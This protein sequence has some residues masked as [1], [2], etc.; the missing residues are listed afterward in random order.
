MEPRV[1]EDKTTPE[2]KK[3]SWKKKFDRAVSDVRRKRLTPRKDGYSPLPASGGKGKGRAGAEGERVFT[4]GG[5]DDESPKD[6]GPPS[7]AK[8]KSSKLGASGKGRGRRLEDEELLRSLAL[9][10]SAPQ[11]RNW[12]KRWLKKVSGIKGGVINPES[13]FMSFWDTT[14]ALVILVV[15]IQAPIEA[16]F[17]P[18]DEFGTIYTELSF[19]DC[20]M[21]IER[22]V[23][24]AVFLADLWMGFHVGFWE[25]GAIVS[26]PKKIKSHYMQTRFVYD[27]LAC[28]PAVTWPVEL[29]AAVTMP[30]KRFAKFAGKSMSAVLHVVA[31]IRLLALFKTVSGMHKL[32]KF[33]EVFSNTYGTLYTEVVTLIIYFTVL[34]SWFTCVWFSVQIF[35]TVDDEFQDHNAWEPSALDPPG[36]SRE[37]LWGARWFLGVQS[38]WLEQQAGALNDAEGDVADPLVYLALQNWIS[39]DSNTS[40]KDKAVL[41]VN[42]FYWAS[43]AGDGYNTVQTMEKMTAIIGQIVFSNFFLAYILGSIISA[44]QEFNRSYKKR[45]LYRTKIDAVNEFLDKHSFFEGM[46]REVR[47]YYQSVWLPM[48]MDFTEESLVKELPHYLKEK[49]MTKITRDVIINSGF[50]TKYF[51]DL[52]QEDPEAVVAFVDL[53]SERVQPM[54]FI[55]K[56]FLIKEGDT[57]TDMYFIKEGN[58][59]VHKKGVGVV[60]ELGPGAYIGEVALL[61]LNPHR[62]ASIITLSNTTVYQLT[63]RDF[64]EIIEEL[65]ET[66]PGIR[67]L[68]ENIAKGWSRTGKAKIRA[69]AALVCQL[70]DPGGPAPAGGG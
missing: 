42:C 38:S 60:V 15:C 66:G 10:P 41:Y 70:R 22:A 5:G 55:P 7:L 45:A 49:V 9:G 17:T 11:D 23:F 59:A 46:K 25:R 35:T 69:A 33:K 2:R 19:G 53:V 64:D 12:F 32:E 27:L 18:T 50:F 28:L 47:E 48:E 34:T 37:D 68:M 39:R 6:E 65:P 20:F 31:M 58:V 1:A 30:Q 63:K 13:R 8:M 24:Y 67:E 4:P 51:A 56:Q 26:D 21:S 57:G 44:L 16:S 43:G 54:Y 36:T 29:F 52:M 40:L 61:G 3:P 62:S 14:V